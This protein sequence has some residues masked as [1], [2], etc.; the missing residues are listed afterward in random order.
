MKH[1]NCR[2]QV[3]S[4]TTST[5]S[6]LAHA[7]QKLALPLILLW[8][9]NSNA[10]AQSSL[11]PQPPH[12]LAP[13][14]V[15]G[16]KLEREDYASNISTVGKIPLSPREIPQSISTIT[17]QRIR[18]QSLTTVDD[19]MKQ[20][21]G[22]TVIA[23]DSS[24]SQ[25]YSR[26]YSMGVA[27]DGIPA[28]RSLS[29]VQQFDLAMYERIEVQRGPAGLF[30]GSGEPGGVVNLVRKRA[31]P[32]FAL[33]GSVSAGSWNRRQADIDVTGPLNEAGSVRARAVLS[34]TDREFFYDSTDNRRWLAY[35]TV[36]WD[37]TP[38]TTLSLAL[39]AQ[40]DQTRASSM[41]LPA[42]ET[43]ELI[44]APRSTNLAPDWG[45]SSWNTR[46]ATAEIEHRFGAGWS[47]V[48]KLS[49]REQ[50]EFFKDAYVTTGVSRLNEGVRYR[51]RV[52][53]FSHTR[54]AADLYA[55]GPV[56]L[57]NRKH[58]VLVGFN[59]ERY[60]LGYERYGWKRPDYWPTDPTGTI[61]FDR[62]DLVPELHAS[63]DQGSASQTSQR[64]VYGSM[65][66]SVTDPL[67]VVVGGR[68]SW[69][70]DKSRDASPSVPGEWRQ[71]AQESSHFTPSGAVLYDL[72]G[73]LT[74]YG[75][76]AG[77]FVPTTSLK[78]DGSTLDPREG[79][80]IEFGAKAEF[81]DGQLQ[82]ST[83]MYEL[84]DTNRA[85]ADGNGYYLNAGEVRSRGWEVELVGRPAP[86]Y[87]IQL[88]YAY[89]RSKYMKDPN[90]Q[91][92]PFQTWE[93]KHSARL[94]GVR[95][96]NAGPLEGFSFGLGLN[97]ASG[98]AAGSGQAAIR[99]QGGYAVAN[100]MASY[101]FNRH[102]TLQLN[103]NNLFD[104]TYYTR[105]GG[106]NSYNTYGEPRNVMMT[107]RA[108]Y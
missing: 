60:R 22:V 107:L 48:G 85:F 44:D 7:H 74:V 12:V 9:A 20:V 87:E 97:V 64:G 75:S 65:R 51:R 18:D 21:T 80:Q 103:A 50:D 105:L 90:N 59:Y 36:E 24:Q 11:T 31:L 5:T 58:E 81:F 39:A 62:A 72:T 108:Q 1:S 61:P 13:V 25:Y 73:S 52:G 49:H 17:S 88:G 95:H 69:F 37:M 45:R 68:L 56:H 10:L 26:G 83:A 57:F 79:E 14:E 28:Y 92:L 2:T 33:S 66:I 106:L 27:Y 101:R 96:F 23:N 78:A 70:N 29:G 93:P 35:G 54:D 40:D 34:A 99:R 86:G 104:R 89:S 102:T 32:A 77:V 84:R 76:Y 91:G 98:S 47:M 3:R 94:W 55:T 38:A 41:G 100:A 43:G 16:D 19:A 63:Y 8:A 82:A 30:M 53:D 67:T 46:E 6:S 42:W 15:H 71:G 4:R